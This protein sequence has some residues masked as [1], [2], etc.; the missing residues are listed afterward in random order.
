MQLVP[1]NSESLPEPLMARGDRQRTLMR[2]AA[3]IDALK[4]AI[5]LENPAWKEFEGVGDG[6]HICDDSDIHAMRQ[7]IESRF[8]SVV[9]VPKARGIWEKG[10]KL[11]ERLLLQLAPLAKNILVV[12]KELQSVNLPSNVQLIP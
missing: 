7:A 6:L 10:K 1:I 8:E 2:Y 12:A 5:R 11:A 9:V 4:T 3:A